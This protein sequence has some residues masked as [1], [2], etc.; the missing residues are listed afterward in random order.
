MKLF[1]KDLDR[2][3]PVVA[4]IG[5]NHEGDLDAAAALMRLAFE[6]GADAA[7][8]QTFTPE[9]YASAS[10]PA[11]L[12]RVRG[13]DLGEEG[14][15]R[16]AEK[17]EKLGFPVFSSAV[18]EDVVPFLAGLFP[19]IKIASG[20]IDFEPVI[21][22]AAGT[23][24]PV[25]LSTGLATE[26]EVDAAVG[27]FRDA[28]GS[29]DIRDRLVLMHCVS[30]YPTPIEEANTA[31]IPYLRERTGLRIGYSNHIVGPEAC[32]AAVALGAC[33]LEV[34]FTDRKEGR[35][36]RDHALSCDADDLARLVEA[37]P[38]IR[39]TVGRPGKDRQPSELENLA[40][41]RKGVV[42]AR[43]LAAGT[44]LAR[45]D[46]MFARPASEFPAAEIDRLPG[47]RLRAGV[48]K[49]ELIERANVDFG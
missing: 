23:G 36:F 16:L 13:F 14:F 48:K 29:D 18:S 12:E 45:E 2:H 32:L 38:R 21:R 20:D 17:A 15:R 27:W 42:A 22:A 49:G 1:G 40:A 34:H 35:E 4:E 24:K 43:D 33:M 9:R 41:V 39:A 8:F 5:V 37:V 19:A 28:A 10:D 46:L 11:R 6:A 31:S 26:A 30:A 7:K 47:A 25:I 44:V 3:V